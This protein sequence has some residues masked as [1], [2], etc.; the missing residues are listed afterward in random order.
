[1]EDEDRTRP[2][3]LFTWHHVGLPDYA[4]IGANLP[5]V[6]NS[7]TQIGAGSC[8]CG[9]KI[10]SNGEVTA[11]R[12]SVSI[13]AVGRTILKPDNIGFYV[14][15]HWDG[16]LKFNGV[17]A[18]RN[19]IH[20]PVDDVH[21]HI[22][23]RERDL[24][25]CILPRTRFIEAVAALRGEDPDASV[26]IG[27]A[28]ELT[29]AASRRVR[30]GL[31]AIIDKGL[32]AGRISVSG[33][34]LFDLTNE[35]FELMM[36]AYLHARPESMDKSGRIRNPARIVRA[37]EDRFAQA[38]L[39]AAAGV[40]KST[41]YLAFQSWCGEPPITYFNKRRLT[42]ARTRLLNS[43]PR[44]GTVTKVALE[45][46]LTELGRFSRDYRRLFGESPSITLNRSM[47]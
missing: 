17:T 23:G 10:V 2:Q 32:R 31:A 3:G 8:I 25:G 37:A 28:L 14:P 33:R 19:A 16:T 44:R 35:L 20:M 45:V 41:L 39:C 6:E 13:H 40:G 26:L 7:L 27:G 42:Q 4:P 1:M 36:E 34:V 22:H 12:A 46:G 9:A 47:G 11:A 30:Q 43:E 18:T 15:L 21:Y 24:A 5:L 29:P 38:G